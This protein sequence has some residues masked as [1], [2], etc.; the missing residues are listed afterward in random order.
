MHPQLDQLIS[1]L[2]AADD[3]HSDRAVAGNF[4]MEARLPA[5]IQLAYDKLPWS[6]LAS[7]DQ[8]RARHGDFLEDEVQLTDRD[9]HP[10]TFRDLNASNCKAQDP[11][12]LLRIE[13]LKGALKLANSTLSVEEVDQ[14]LRERSTGGD[15]ARQAADKILRRFLD[16]WNDGRDR[17]PQFAT[18]RAGV[19]HLLPDDPRAAGDW[20]WVSDL[21]DHLGLGGYVPEANGDA[22]PVLIMVY[23]LTDVIAHCSPSWDGRVAVPTVLDG[24]LFEY[25]F[26]SPVAPNPSA[27]GEHYPVGRTL[28]LAPGL[29]M[30]DYGDQ[31]GTEL[32]HPSFDYQPQH[33]WAVAYVKRH[34][35]AD[36][37]LPGRRACHLAW[38]RLWA[39]HEGFGEGVPL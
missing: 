36:F 17:R 33:C 11:I 6:D 9:E 1:R 37:S 20:G 21:R 5:D 23:P 25:F 24:D 14:R 34:L 7:V 15:G 3:N 2:L 8:W 26:P 31:M 16:A 27:A 13:S 28:N 22:F 39:D 38:V 29:D 4:R 35:P 18:N 30:N 12:T 10:W 19:E 32:L